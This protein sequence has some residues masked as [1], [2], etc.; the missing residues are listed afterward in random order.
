MFFWMFLRERDHLP[1][2]EIGQYRKGMRVRMF[3]C[4]CVTE[5]LGVFRGN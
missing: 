1:Y 5:S 3:V 4:V 2:R